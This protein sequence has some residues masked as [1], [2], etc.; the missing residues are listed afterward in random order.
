MSATKTNIYVLM[1]ED[2]HVKYVG[3][4]LRSLNKRFGRHLG[5]ALH[6]I[7][8]HRCN[9]IRSMLAK[10]SKPTMGLLAIVEG[11]GCVEEIAY[12]AAFKKSGAN[13]TNG[14]AGGEG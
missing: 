10:G 1:D 8:N 12:I 5:E 4:T 7:K 2:C 14:T 3:K 9:W 11:N 13:L 6:G